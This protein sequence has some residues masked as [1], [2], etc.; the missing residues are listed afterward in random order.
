MVYVVTTSGTVYAFKE[1][2]GHLLWSNDVGNPVSA[3]LAVS[4]GFVYVRASNGY[5]YELN[6]VTGQ[7]LATIAPTPRVTPPSGTTPTP[8]PGTM[9]TPTPGVT[10][11]ATPGTTPTLTPTSGVT[12]TATPGTTPTPTPTSGVT[13][14]PTP[15]ETPSSVPTLVATKTSLPTPENRPRQQEWPVGNKR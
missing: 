12:P 14:T 8:T 5:P 4:N 11:T 6:A 13:P 7:L 3:P 9:P 10:P 15:G 2:N 1:C